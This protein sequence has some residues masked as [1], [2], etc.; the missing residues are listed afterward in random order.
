MK[1]DIIIIGAGPGGYEMAAKAVQKGL[2]VTLVEK[3]HL[4][5]TCL[6]RGCIPT[7]VLCRNAE[8]FEL[9]HNAAAFGVSSQPFTLDFSAVMARKDEVIAQLREGIS[10]LLAKV[11][12]VQGEGV[13]KD[14]HTICVGEESYEADYI[15]IATGSS[16]AYLP[17]EGVELPGVITSDDLLSCTELPKT[18][19][20]VGGGVIGME[21]AA[22]FSSFGTE[23]TVVEYCKEILP[24]F[25]KDVAKRL[26]TVLG[27][28]GVNIVVGAAVKEIKL[29]EGKLIVSYEQKNKSVAVE[30]E[31]VLMSVG[32]KPIVPNGAEAIGIEVGRRGI[33]VDE[34]MRTN[35]SNI[36]AIGDVNG[37]CML[38][39]A[40]SFQGERALNAI[41]ADKNVTTVKDEIDFSI[42]PGAVF[43]VPELGMVGM[44]EE[45]CEAQGIE[46]T[47][48]KAMF[49]GNGKALAM[50]EPDG[51]VKL[52]VRND[53]RT[54]IGCHICGAHAA[55]LV[56]EVV[57]A[58]NAKMTIDHFKDVI[59]G[60]P[61]LGE[62]VATA[63]AQF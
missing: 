58:M 5:G 61:T 19:C 28:K 6:N 39:H 32:R 43:T 34:N 4:G 63:A 22:I 35:I 56:Q 17:I 46:V 52:I 44:T 40:A 30:C 57:V 55:D 25:D 42:I 48:K 13:V 33:V 50:N 16:P 21:F 8:V 62:V 60:H 27:K 14:A 47:S 31:K 38:A 24:N 9:L 41:I 18:L 15:V 49:R 12:I 59:H 36:F 1:T 51:I 3:G 53:D 7:K 23:V 20:I 2:S 26:R 45:Q 11:N 10:T 29:G 54:I 37:R